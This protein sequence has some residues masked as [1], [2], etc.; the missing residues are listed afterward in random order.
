MNEL[1]N[2]PVV[3]IHTVTDGLA[4]CCG[5]PWKK[6]PFERQGTVLWACTG[7]F[8]LS[9]P[10]VAAPK[11][12]G[13]LMH[14]NGEYNA[15]VGYFDSPAKLEAAV[16]R[17]NAE[18]WDTE[19][20]EEAA[21]EVDTI[22]VRVVPDVIDDDFLDLLADMLED[23]GVYIESASDRKERLAEQ[24]AE[25]IAEDVLPPPTVVVPGQIGID[26]TIKE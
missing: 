9:R 14:D 15:Y 17:L 6:D 25:R 11:R 23:A 4:D 10:I 26:G 18:R 13:V 12:I 3:V 16:R 24:E 21:A 1:P 7:C 8:N 2:Y 5:L 22:E 20:M 19:A